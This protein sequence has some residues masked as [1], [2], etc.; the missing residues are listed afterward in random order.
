M[1]VL[2]WDGLGDEPRMTTNVKQLLWDCIQEQLM[3]TCNRHDPRFKDTPPTMGIYTIRDRREA[4][5]APLRAAIPEIDDDEW[6]PGHEIED[7]LLSR[8]GENKLG[9]YLGPEFF[10]TYKQEQTTHGK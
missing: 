3:D 7:L 2:D 1:K 8:L 5:R 6:A 10:P 9:D 4:F